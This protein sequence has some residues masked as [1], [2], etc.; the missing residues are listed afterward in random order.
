MTFE[1][2]LRPI[3]LH[4]SAAKASF[5]VVFDWLSP[6]EVEVSLVYAIC[7]DEDRFVR[8]SANTIL[9]TR[10]ELQSELL[11]RRGRTFPEKVYLQTYDP[12]DI[13]VNLRQ[14]Y[15]K[16]LKVL[17]KRMHFLRG[18]K[19]TMRGLLGTREHSALCY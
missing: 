13:T 5:R 19:F 4:D 16:V 12:A 10:G 11:P 14:T 6:S 8:K 9:D 1:S 18:T 3:T 15:S 2:L 17:A 7:R